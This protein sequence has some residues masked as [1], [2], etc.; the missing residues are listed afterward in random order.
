M[1]HILILESIPRVCNTVCSRNSCKPMIIIMLND[2][3][4]FNA[5]MSLPRKL[6]SLGLVYEMTV[7]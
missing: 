3:V 6:S 4:T 5:L 2:A 7:S 1:F